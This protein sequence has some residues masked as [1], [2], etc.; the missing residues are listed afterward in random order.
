[1]LLW[2]CKCTSRME[3]GQCS[4]AAQLHPRCHFPCPQSQMS[5]YFKLLQLHQNKT[6]TSI[7][8][9]SSPSKTAKTIIC[10]THVCPQTR[11]PWMWLNHEN[12]QMV[13]QNQVFLR[14]FKITVCLCCLSWQCA[15]HS[16]KLQVG[17][18]GGAAAIRDTRGFRDSQ[19]TTSARFVSVLC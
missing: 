1:M 19:P 6:F 15:E 10:L 4:D 16:G 5:D 18:G 8:L 7:T 11:L 12:I 13:K 9:N 3:A 2:N 14:A 17:M